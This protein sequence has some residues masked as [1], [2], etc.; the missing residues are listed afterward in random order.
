MVTLLMWTEGMLIVSML[1]T[2]IAMVVMM[3]TAM[4]DAV[5]KTLKRATPMATM[6]RWP[7]SVPR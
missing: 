5:G 3:V 2:I 1:A 7:K 4:H 6:V